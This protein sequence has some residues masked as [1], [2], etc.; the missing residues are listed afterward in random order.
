MPHTITIQE[1]ER[2]G[3]RDRK[4]ANYVVPYSQAEITANEQGVIDSALAAAGTVMSGRQMSHLAKSDDT[5]LTNAFASLFYSLAYSIAG[6]F[7][8]GGLLLLAY[9]VLGGD[10]GIYALVFLVLWGC[11]FLAALAY[12]RWQGL[13]FSPAGLEHHEI[14]SRERIAIHAID[15]HLDL[16][17]R[18]WR[19]KS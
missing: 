12:N 1:Q 7:I 10:E 14:D 8:S 19:L 2:L 16:I 6:A 3:L 11:C 15:K 18:R 17:E 13:W 9:C 4:P 5:A